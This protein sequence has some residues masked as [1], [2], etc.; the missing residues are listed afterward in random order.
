MRIQC[1]M[2]GYVTNSN[3]RKVFRCP[4]CNYRIVIE[5][6]RR[7]KEVQKHDSNTAM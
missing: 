6:V 3:G 4:W 7:K 1:K 5:K 2:C